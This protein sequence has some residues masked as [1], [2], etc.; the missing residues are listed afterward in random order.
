MK[1]FR[2]LLITALLLGPT[3]FAAVTHAADSAKTMFGV[4]LGSR[5][6]IPACA[7]G[8]DTM[9]KRYCHAEALSA[10][11]A[12]GSQEHHVF[13]PRAETVPWARGEMIVDVSNGVIEAIHINTW[14]IEAQTL[15]LDA[16]TLKYG[17]PARSRSEK[18]KG[19]RSRWPTK[20]AEWDLRDFS[21]KLDGTTGSVDWGRVTLATP[22]HQ[23]MRKAAGK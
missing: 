10:K 1:T 19:L 14:G 2:H 5:F 18:I 4:E 12:W 17:P 9:A 3:F 22:R 21:V 6:T 20:Y 23:S 13:Y 7:R 16:M 15:A 8:E 11:T